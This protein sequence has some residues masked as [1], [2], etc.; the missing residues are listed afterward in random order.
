VQQHEQSPTPAPPDSTTSRRRRLDSL[1]TGSSTAHSP[2]PY[3]ERRRV[4]PTLGE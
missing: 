4:A 1:R 3:R 2:E